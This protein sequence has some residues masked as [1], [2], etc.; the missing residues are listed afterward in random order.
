MLVPNVRT[1]LIA[2]TV[3]QAARLRVSGAAS[4]LCALISHIHATG[5]RTLRRHG[6]ER[7][8]RRARGKIA[9]KRCD[10]ET[11]GLKTALRRA[12]R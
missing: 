9:G 10:D 8:V 3:R 1:V 5:R 12:I 4:N 2:R 11:N 6:R 7:D